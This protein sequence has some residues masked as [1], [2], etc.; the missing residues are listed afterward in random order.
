MLLPC[1]VQCPYQCIL[2]V[3]NTERTEL[4]ECIAT[5]IKLLFCLLLIY[6]F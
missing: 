4:N 1:A 5:L 3:E 2:L 6:L